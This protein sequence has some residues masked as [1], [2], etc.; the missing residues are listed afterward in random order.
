MFKN[1][2]VSI[3]TAGSSKPDLTIIDS[4]DYFKLYEIIREHSD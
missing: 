3:M 2:N 4:P 1:G